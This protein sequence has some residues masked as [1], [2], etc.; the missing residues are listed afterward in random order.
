VSGRAI[1][2][3]ELPRHSPWPARL[4]GLEGAEREPRTPASVLREFDRDKY[5]PL[6]RAVEADPAL[7]VDDVKALEL[8]QGEVVASDGERLELLDIGEAFARTTAAIVACV[9]RHVA[10]ARTVVDLGCGY[11]H[12]LAAIGR[13]HPGLG[14]HGGEF[15]GSGRELGRRLGFDI[16]AV[17][18]AGGEL[19]PLERAQ[20]PAVVLLAMVAQNLPSA[21]LAVAALAPYRDKL[22]AV[23]V[24]DVVER[25]LSDGLLGLLR[26]RYVQFNRYSADFLDVV[27]AR[28]DVELLE[29]EPN[30]A[31][32]NALLPGSLVV[33]RFR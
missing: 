32:P 16:D 28:G 29:F 23:V 2:L 17:D 5:G 22:A 25:A 21:E 19:P 3:D 30:V 18:L 11:G 33:W 6:L 15:A 4:L 9:G 10:G 13:A 24:Y 12:H 26:R 7:T 8:G 20:G 27:E 31:S 1:A 14:L